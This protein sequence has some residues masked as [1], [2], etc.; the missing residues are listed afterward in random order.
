MT[1]DPDAT[2]DRK[3]AGLCAT[4]RH[5]ITQGTKRGSVFYRCGRADDDERFRRYP[6]IPVSACPG[7]E[8]DAREPD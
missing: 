2:R 4:C 5:V 7:F 3:A 8:D 6:P 1:H